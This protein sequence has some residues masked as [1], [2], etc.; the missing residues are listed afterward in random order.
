M[1]I[2]SVRFTK[3]DLAIPTSINLIAALFERYGVRV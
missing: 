3:E 2:V 1:K